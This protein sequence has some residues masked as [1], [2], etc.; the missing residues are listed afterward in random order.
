MILPRQALDKHRENSKKE[1]RFLA[2]IGLVLNFVSMRAFH[3][4]QAA[5]MVVLFL[6]R[7]CHLARGG[8]DPGA[9]G[10]GGGSTNDLFDVRNQ[11]RLLG[12]AQE[13]FR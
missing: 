11:E 8:D 2:G 4:Y 7:D 9:G 6:W 3:T 13:R 1:Y 12:C 5:L 10:S